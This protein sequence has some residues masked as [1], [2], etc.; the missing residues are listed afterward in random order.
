MGDVSNSYWRYR[1][2]TDIGGRD[3][4]GL[5]LIV[6]QYWGRRFGPDPSKAPYYFIIEKRV[7]SFKVGPCED[8]LTNGALGYRT[9]PQY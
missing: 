8:A 6:L 1:F 2:F 4:K 5:A 7:P 3:P 9:I